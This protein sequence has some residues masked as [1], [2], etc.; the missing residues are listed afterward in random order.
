MKILFALVFLCSVVFADCNTTAPNNCETHRVMD[1][2]Y[3]NSFRD[4]I[5]YDNLEPR[6]QTSL[7]AMVTFASYKLK[8]KHHVAQAEQI[9]KEWGDLNRA[10]GWATLGIG[11]HAPLNAWL[12][13]WY[14]TLEFVLGHNVMVATRLVDIDTL[15]HA[16]KVVFGCMGIQQAEGKPLLE[17]DFAI[18]FEEMCGVVA[19]WGTFFACVGF[20][21]G[22]GFLFCSPLAWG[23]E[24]LIGDLIAPR[25]SNTV[26]KKRCF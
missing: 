6:I 20:T 24:F 4:D 10:G 26:W 19:Y 15:N 13:K 23:A 14:H 5:A 16:L 12:D 17:P 7:D 3:G 2:T 21:W 1:Q 25:F 9:L 11:D 22:T 18:H 8:Q